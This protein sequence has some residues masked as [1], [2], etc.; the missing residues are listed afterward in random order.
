M[1]QKLNLF[2]E[3]SRRVGHLAEQAIQS[4]Q[5]AIADVKIAAK[6][7]QERVKGLMSDFEE[8][9]AILSSKTEA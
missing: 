3:G 4:G 6:K 1:T 7:M 9:V 2:L 8:R 5:Q